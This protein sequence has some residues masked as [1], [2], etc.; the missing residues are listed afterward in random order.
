MRERVNLNI[1]K[2]QLL[3]ESLIASGDLWNRCQHIIK[4]E[5]WD[6]DLRPS[7]EYMI[8][9]NKGYRALPDSPQ[10]L[11]ETGIKLTPYNTDTRDKFESQSQEIEKF[12]LHKAVEHAI[13]K[14]PAL[15]DKEDWGTL[16]DSLKDAVGVSLLKKIGT[17][18]FDDVEA[19]LRLA[20]ENDDTISTGWADVDKILGGGITRKEL[21]LFLATSGGGKSITMLNLAK[22][23]M[24][25]GY[26]GVYYTLEMSEDVV[27][28]RLDMM[29]SGINFSNILDQIDYVAPI[30]QEQQG[31][32]GDLIIKKFPASTTTALTLAS[33]I[34]EIELEK[35][36]TPDFVVVDYLDLL[37]PTAKVGRDNLFISEKF[38][39]E[40]IRNISDEF[41]CMMISASQM[42]RSAVNAQDHDH[43]MISGGISKINTAGW[44]ISLVQNEIM[45]SAQEMMMQFLKTRSS[46]GVGKKVYLDRS[47]K[48]Q[49]IVDSGRKNPMNAEPTEYD[50][51]NKHISDE[52]AK[53]TTNDT[54]TKLIGMFN[55]DDE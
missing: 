8:T 29:M 25:Q 50:E 20:A 19:R 36:W 10:I 6:I 22:N 24:E 15:L 16:V 49:V 34:K 17:D 30:V 32:M 51:L 40:E 23:L 46:D 14:A 5:Y 35:K 54:A 13:K 27:S 26:R 39:A 18:Y 45:K 43:S 52:L 4:P 53:T 38:V 41:N 2:Q 11:A 42:N 1:E 3:L 48:T 9:Y 21:L 55:N 33:H 7:L 12:C 47:Q 44:V 37:A 28:R 31:K